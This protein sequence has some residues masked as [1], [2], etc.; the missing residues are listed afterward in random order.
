MLLHRLTRFALIVLMLL[1]GGLAC[2]QQLPDNPSPSAT[3]T[4]SD[5]SQDQRITNPPPTG[6]S[7][8][9]V[10]TGKPAQQQGYITYKTPYEFW[11]TG[12]AI[13]LVVT[14][15]ILLCVMAAIGKLTQEFYKAFL[16][17]VV[18]FAALF[19]IVAGYTDT[20]TAP[21][22]SLLGTIV[23]YIFGKSAAGAAEESQGQPPALNAANAAPPNQAAPPG[24]AT[25]LRG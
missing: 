18:V 5:V 8:A 3:A 7:P 22:F 2:A 16:L 4:P 24:T 17:L 25:A 19:L 9:S 20:Q 6:Q 1:C 10:G 23:G 14:M 21:V 12:L 11:L 15:A 13:A